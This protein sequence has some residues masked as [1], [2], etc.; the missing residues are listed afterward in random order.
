MNDS[1]E[2]TPNPLNP[3]PEAE[4]P[5]D[6]MVE[7]LAGPGGD[8]IET[9]APAMESEP[10]VAQAEPTGA[11]M[12]TMRPAPVRMARPQSRAVVDPMMRPRNHMP[13]M[14]ARAPMARPEVAATSTPAP[15][16]EES[17]TQ[18]PV[19][20]ETLGRTEPTEQIVRSM[21]MDDLV[22]KDSVVLPKPGKKSKRGLVVAAAV[23]FLVAIVCGAAAV[24]MFLL[25][26]DDSR[27][28]AAINKALD[29]GLPSI[30]RVNGDITITQTEGEAPNVTAELDGTFDT[31]TKMSKVNAEATATLSNGQ[32]LDFELDELQSK[33]GSTYLKLTNVTGLADGLTGQVLQTIDGQ[34][35]MIPKNSTGSEFTKQLD[36]L[37]LQNNPSVC[38]SNAL[39]SMPEYSKDIAT[40]YRKN[41]FISYSTEKLQINRKKNPLYRLSFDENK[42]ASFI[43]GMSNSGLLNEFNA[44]VGGNATNDKT[45]AAELSKIFGGYPTVYV[46]I[47]DKYNFTRVYFATEVD[48][49]NVTAD[50]ALSYPT[51]IEV[52]EPA[53]YLDLSTLIS[54]AMVKFMNG[55]NDSGT[56]ET[57]VVEF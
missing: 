37:G 21:P 29:N 52:T 22:A 11:S 39:M 32:S 15:E 13:V 6:P 2:G 43:N 50:L 38:L 34:W 5:V 24:A 3:A 55:Q 18:E 30:I 48:G 17:M 53:E 36:T 7:S 31:K 54:E 47:D 35:V 51:K 14:P 20:R 19:G 23:L 1:L 27:V 57:V 44:C 28:A 40:E 46:E 12:P 16:F 45:S 4:A 8:F 10:P 56:V 33:D 49:A 26:K 25:S 9:P 41:Q 42:F